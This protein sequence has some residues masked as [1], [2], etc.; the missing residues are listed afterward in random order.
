MANQKWIFINFFELSRSSCGEKKRN[1]ILK[2][3]ISHSMWDMTKMLKVDHKIFSG[4]FYDK[5]KIKNL[6]KKVLDKE[7]IVKTSFIIKNLQLNSRV[8]KEKKF[9]LKCWISCNKSGGKEYTATLAHTICAW[10]SAQMQCC[11]I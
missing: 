10:G 4:K 2:W 3:F 7:E 9:K 11:T 8:R 5:R 6:S 1:L